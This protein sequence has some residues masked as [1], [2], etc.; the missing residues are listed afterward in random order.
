MAYTRNM[1]FVGNVMGAPGEMSGWVYDSSG[2]GAWNSSS[3]WMLGW[4]NNDTAWDPDAKATT[5]R[6]GN[7]DFVT[8][9]QRWETNPGF[10]GPLPD[11]LYL[12]TKPAFFGTNP[13]PWVD[14]AT[15]AVHTLPAKARFDAGTPNGP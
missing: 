8:M 1:S 7:Y 5:L 14:P 10:T 2:P 9:T 15:G 11:S 4:T 13:W 12:T 6:D 3:I